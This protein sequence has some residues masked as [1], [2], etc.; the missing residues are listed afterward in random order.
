MGSYRHRLDIIADI[1]DVVSRDAKKTQIMYQANLS[2][3]VMQKY[4]AELIDASLLSYEDE[5]MV[6]VITDKG[7]DFLRAYSEYSK[8]NKRAA[9]RLSEARVKKKVLE[10][11]C[12]GA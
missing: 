3:A 8:T 5:R 12:S 7:R 1:L 10:K 6:Y 4:L 2:Y 9:K 11:L